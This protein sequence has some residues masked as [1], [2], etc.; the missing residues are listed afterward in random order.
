MS[1]Y[2]SDLLSLTIHTKLTWMERVLKNGDIGGKLVCPNEK[3]GVKIGNFDWAG[4][5]CGCKEWVTPVRCACHLVSF[6]DEMGQGFCIHRS[7][8]DE[9]W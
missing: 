5:Q 2:L 6:A 7:K 1:L 9:V 3:C 8:V 4:V